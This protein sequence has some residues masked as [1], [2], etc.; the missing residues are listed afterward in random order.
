M[1]SFLQLECAHCNEEG[2]GPRLA[3]QGMCVNKLKLKSCNNIYMIKINA[4]ST[5]NDYS[6]HLRSYISVHAVHT[7]LCLMHI[8]LKFRHQETDHVHYKTF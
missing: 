4:Q 5:H 2:L 1:F 3:L 8:S 6:F 7:R